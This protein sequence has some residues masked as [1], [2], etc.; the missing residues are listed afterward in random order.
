MKAKVIYAGL[1]MFLISLSFT[2]C[3]EENDLDDFQV[4]SLSNKQKL[5]KETSL[6]LGNILADKKA[7]DEFNSAMRRASKDGD[8]VSFAY[9]FDREASL[10]R[11]EL[12]TFKS[13][14]KKLDAF[15]AALVKE[16]NQNRDNYEELNKRVSN[17][18]SNS[19]RTL[20]DGLE[21]I[22][23]TEE[24]QVFY[25]YDPE[26]ADDDMTVTDFYVSFDPLDGSQTNIGYKYIDGTSDVEIIEDLDN[27][28]LDE[29][30]VYV[31]VPIDP[32]DIPG[33][34][35][36]YTDLQPS[37][38]NPFTDE[39]LPYDDTQLF[40]GGNLGGGGNTSG[41]NTGGGTSNTPTTELLTDNA[42]HSDIPESDIISSY[43][44]RIQINGTSWMGFGGTH[45]K[46]RFY[47]A[48]T[49]GTVTQ[50]ADGTITAGANNYLIKYY[51]CK[52]KFVRKKYW[53]DINAEFDPDWNMSENTQ[54]MAIFSVHHISASA[55]FELTTKSGFKLE[56][57]EVKPNAEASGT[58]KITVSTGSAKFRANAEMSRRFILA[59]IV[60][61]G[62]TGQT[63]SDNGVDY[64]VKNIG[65]VKYYMKHF[66]T[67]FE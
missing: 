34:P 26:Y 27:D 35:C 39:I 63:F 12:T 13:R 22:L 2:S 36:Q 33:E 44:P 19:S 6:L 45:Q 49:D 64:N 55:S 18:L 20:S 14:S 65:I 24:L 4:S 53:V 56:N 52:R 1:I 31:V 41:G 16:L 32:C 58:R 61:E 10:K 23:V 9:L 48:T 7:K 60:G 15:R 3:S 42:N 28:F 38:V 46:L 5:I 54:S 47:R 30:P 29:N 25:P 59:T 40:A 21:D 66:Y 17:I 51:R 8:I 43:I 67:D 37:Q 11:N 57:G 50:N 62:T